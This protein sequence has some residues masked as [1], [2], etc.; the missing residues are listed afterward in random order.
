MTWLSPTDIQDR[1]RV[2]RTTAFNLMKDYKANGG[3]YIKIG[4]LTRVN[5]EQFEQYL[6][7]ASKK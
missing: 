7:G 4:K 2:K 6:K 1:F 3:E 5:A